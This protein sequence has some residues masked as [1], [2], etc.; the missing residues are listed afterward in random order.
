[1]VDRSSPSNSEGS[2]FSEYHLANLYRTAIRLGFEVH[3]F[4]VT[5]QHPI[6]KSTRNTIDS[7]YLEQRNGQL[8]KI[9]QII[10]AQN[11]KKAIVVTAHSEG[12]ITP[13]KRKTLKETSPTIGSLLYQ[14]YVDQLFA[15]SLL[16]VDAY[17]K[18][19]K[20]D[21]FFSLFKLE[22]SASGINTH[23]SLFAIPEL[24]NYHKENYQALGYDMLK[25]IK[26]DMAKDH[27]I[28][29]FSSAEIKQHGK[30][31][32]PFYVKWNPMQ[33]IDI[34]LQHGEYVVKV[35]D[36]MGNLTQSISFNTK[37]Q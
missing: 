32:V 7:S 5:D 34:P 23:A 29:I 8:K 22:P 13:V 20:G 1:L 4:D 18:S 35:S 30:H 36:K 24:H 9:E 10:S 2:Y 16:N 37:L 3:D 31:A 17:K 6:E 14:R 26:V 25:T 21:K 33:T 15:I 11:I 28:S 19:R 12:S 27:Y